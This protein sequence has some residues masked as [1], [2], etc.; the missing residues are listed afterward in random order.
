MNA[1]QLITRI[2]KGNRLPCLYHFTDT[3]NIPS[4]AE[5]GILSRSQL[6]AR[7]V[8][9]VVFGGN[10]W[11]HDQDDRK[12]VSDYVHLCFFESHPMEFMAKKDERIAES[13]FIKILPEV[14]DRDGVKFCAG[15][16]NAADAELFGIEEVDARLDLEVLFKRT[17]WKNPEIQA[18]LKMAKKYE[19]LIPN[20]VPKKFLR[21]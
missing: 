14:L 2:K 8:N 12:G 1:Q 17:D 21:K 3:R 16:A 19:V 20:R 15:V 6:A 11:S 9:D 4:I 10:S 18:R 5:H 13:F 7:A